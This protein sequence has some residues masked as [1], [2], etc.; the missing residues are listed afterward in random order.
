M[1]PLALKMSEIY[2]PFKR[3][4]V[5]MFAFLVSSQILSLV[6]P[7][8]YGKVIDAIIARDEINV[9]MGLACLSFL[10]YILRDSVLA[11]YKD[12][13]ELNYLDFTVSEHIANTTLQKIMGFSVG[14]HNSQNSG[15]KQSI[16]NRGQ[17]SLQQLTQL[18][19]W[20]VLPMALQLTLTM[21]VL[22]YLNAALGLIVLLSMILL[23]AAT[24]YINLSLDKEMGRWQDIDND[25]YKLHAEILRNMELIKINSQEER[26]SAE[27][28]SGLKNFAA[29]GRELWQKHS[30]YSSIRSFIL[31]ASKIAV[32]IVGILQVYRG[33]YTPGY[34]VFF[35]SLSSSAFGNLDNIRE[36]HRSF[37]RFYARVKKFFELL[38]IEP[39]VK[40][41]KKPVRLEKVQGGIEF[42]NVFFVYQREDQKSADE[43]KDTLLDIN[44]KI[45]PGEKVALVGH[46][47]AGK[48][49]IA[50][51]I[52]RAHDPISGEILIDGKELKSLD[53]AEYLKQIGSVEQNVSLFD[54]T[55]RY[56]ILFGL[57]QKRAEEITEDELKE[58]AEA[59]CIDNFFYRLENGFDTV[60]GE[61]G[62]RLSGGERQRVGIAR[63]LIKKPKILIFDEA[64]SSLDT[65]NE[66]L[67]KKA[68]DKASKGRTTIIIAHRLSTIKDVDKIFVLDHGRLVGQGAHDELTQ[69]CE[70]YRAL[71]SN[72]VVTI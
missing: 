38:E 7:F 49:T 26:M 29:V 69:S 54:K 70:A 25:N 27:Y 68:I 67:I 5:I 17:S 64:T 13:F 18:I 31:S 14:Q 20:R 35:L 11:Y 40:V 4:I 41:L 57:D 10:V 9:V 63:A 53:L 3:P 42:Q 28:D 21:M 46:S 65:K 71:I 55:I 58:A 50:S 72:Q 37:L 8:L 59:A 19:L 62:I 12:K 22:L 30:F 6:S 33:D 34:L 39:D 60:I 24:V 44:L 61:K 23:S 1:K 47:G 45:N 2:R 43:K 16:I 15:L 66:E 32:I 52:L 36:I 48:S 51:L 56:N